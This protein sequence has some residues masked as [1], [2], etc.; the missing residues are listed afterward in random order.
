MVGTLEDF[1]PGVG[2]V[3]AVNNDPV[4]VVNTRQGIRVFSAVCTHLGCVVLDKKPGA[5]YI[6]CPC[7][8][9]WFNPLNGAVI[10]GVPPRPLPAYE[11]TVN[12]GKIYVGK[13]LGVLYGA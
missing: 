5:A 3:V 4:I 7:H 13:P 12:D 11:L 6:A 8:D 2:K 1:P 10:D 9:G